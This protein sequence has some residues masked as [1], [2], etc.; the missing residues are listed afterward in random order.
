MNLWIF[1]CFGS[2]HHLYRIDRPRLEWPPVEHVPYPL[3]GKCDGAIGPNGVLPSTQE[4][5]KQ[6]SYWQESGFS[7]VS[8]WDRQGDP[9]TGSHTGILAKGNYTAEE[10]VA[11]GRKQYPRAFRVDVKI[12]GSNQ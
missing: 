2:G 9:R 12:G 1:G 8:W 6:A 11:E 5:G 3:W 7:F 10:L 4:E